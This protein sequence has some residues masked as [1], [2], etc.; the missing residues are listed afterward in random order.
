MAFFGPFVATKHEAEIRGLRPVAWEI[1]TA[2]VAALEGAMR[3]CLG[4][5]GKGPWTQL[6][7][8]PV[9]KVSNSTIA[10]LVLDERHVEEGGPQF[11]LLK[12]E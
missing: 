6:L 3:D 11:L 10:R 7:G 8:V 2:W 4:E 1:P 9:K 12:D 5:H